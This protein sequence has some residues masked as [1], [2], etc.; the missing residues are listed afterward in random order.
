[1]AIEA[2]NDQT[3]RKKMKSLFSDVAPR[4]TLIIKLSSAQRLP[5]LG[6]NQVKPN[7]AIFSNL[8]QDI[9]NYEIY[10]IPKLLIETY[11]M[12]AIHITFSFIQLSIFLLRL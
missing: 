11:L 7:I 9:G 1:M 3:A 2:E 6:A 5:S 10:I 12:N 8:E 4:V